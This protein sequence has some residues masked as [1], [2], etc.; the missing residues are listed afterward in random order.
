MIRRILFLVFGISLFNG[1]L[2]AQNTKPSQK[3]H[4]Y[5]LRGEKAFEKNNWSLSEA[6]FDSCLQIDP[7]HFDAHYNRAICRENQQ[8]IEGAINDYGAMI[9]LNPTF[10]EALWSR[11]TL[12]YQIGH[13]ELAN[14]DFLMLLELPENETNAVYFSKKYPD[15]GVSAISTLETMQGQIHNYLGMVSHKLENYQE[16]IDYYYQA[17][18][19]DS[20]NSDL[21]VNRSQTYEVLG[22]HNLAVE[23][24]KQAIEIDPAN[25]IAMYNLARLQELT[26]SESGELVKTYDAIIENSPAFAEAYAQRGLAKLKTGNLETALH[27]YDSAIYYDKKDARLWLNRG[28]I[29]MRLGYY[30]HAINDFSKAISLKKGLEDAY[31]NRGNTYMKIGRFNDARKDYDVAISYYP[32]FDMAYYNRGIAYY[33]LGNKLQACEDIKKALDLGFKQAEET[34]RKM[35]K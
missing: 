11:A 21:Y 29:H 32:D 10:T 25:T 31:L 12:R 18:E 3:A 16:A 35:C 6:Y 4:A 5:F 2:H 17:L 14:E 24:L 19:S 1:Y 15:Q 27:D 30:D 22:K 33:N 26:H 13:Y 23:D 34:L 8:N 9:Y 20:L 7:I 28:I